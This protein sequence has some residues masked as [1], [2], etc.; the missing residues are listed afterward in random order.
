MKERLLRLLRERNLTNAR[1]AEIMETQPSNVSHILSG[2]NNPGYD[3][4][5]KLIEKF[6]DINPSWLLTGR[7]GMYSGSVSDAGNVNIRE[8]ELFREPKAVETEPLKSAHVPPILTQMS[9]QPD[10]LTDRNKKIEKVLVIYDD[11]TF[12]EYLPETEKR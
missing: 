6:P 9:P 4:I 2:R 10:N 11:K 7:G 8:P 5:V 12:V 3:F 1:F